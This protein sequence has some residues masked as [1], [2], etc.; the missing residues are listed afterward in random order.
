MARPRTRIGTFGKIKVTEL[1]KATRKEPGLYEARTRFRMRNGKLKP[2]KRRAATETA[3]ENAVKVACSKLTDEVKG[4]KISGDSRF[5]HVA[6]LWLESLERKVEA[7][8]R[9]PKTLYDYRDTVRNHV[10]PRLGELSCREVQEDVG[11]CDE[12]IKAVQDQVIK[13]KAKGAKRGES[14]VSAARRT[15]VV[16][17]GICGWAMRQ[18]AM[19][20]NPI[21]SAETIDTGQ[22][23][24]IRALERDERGDFLA[25]LEKVVTARAEDPKRRLGV[26]GQGWLDLPDIARAGLATGARIGEVLALSADDVDLTLRRVSLTHHL[27]RVEG[28]GIVRQPLRKGGKP[29][30][31]LKIP[32]WAVAMFRDR[33]LQSGGGMLWRTWNGGME[34]PS[35]VMKRLRKVADEIGYGWLTS[36]VFRKTTASHL[37]DKNVPS[38]AIADQLGNTRDVVEGHYRRRQVANERTADALESMF[39]VPEGESSTG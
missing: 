18:G 37:G 20:A 28:V 24:E 32:S 8:T 23:K 2:V 16:L 35:N 15:R 36:H 9:A 11:L 12:V 5:G 4:K 26:R 1:R 33:K 34:D 30:M 10:K 29:A 39:D 19:T 7:G 3:A 25:K 38:E 31:V 27:V 13:A 22:K 21:K 14:G 17:S 6:D